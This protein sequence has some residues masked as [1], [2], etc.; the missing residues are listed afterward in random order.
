MIPIIQEYLPKYKDVI[1]FSEVLIK[2]QEKLL[3]LHHD[4]EIKINDTNIRFSTKPDY[5]HVYF[6]SMPTPAMTIWNNNK[7]SS[8]NCI[9]NSEWLYLSKSVTR[10]DD[11]ELSGTQYLDE[12]DAFDFLM[13]LQYDKFYSECYKLHAGICRS[14]N[15]DIIEINIKHF[16][17]HKIY[18]NEVMEVM[19]KTPIFWKGV[20]YEF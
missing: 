15:I 3:S 20:Y 18:L 16:F 4:L 6:G 17:Y 19:N 10:I 2:Y 5:I 9:Y 14:Q 11:F 1:K 7:D 12:P 8:V 13:D